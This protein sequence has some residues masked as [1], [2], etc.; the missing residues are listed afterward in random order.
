VTEGYRQVALDCETTGL[1]PRKGS[2]VIEVGCVEVV[3]RRLTGNTW[4]RRV[5]PGVPIDPG[6]THVHGITNA[7]L[8]G[9]PTFA[10]IADE[11]LSWIGKTDI[12]GHNLPF[13]LDH[14][15]NE[16]NKLDTSRWTTRAQFSLEHYC[17]RD[18][19]H[20]SDIDTIVLM[21]RHFPGK[22][23]SLDSLCKLCGVDRS[24]RVVHGALLDA[25]LTAECYLKMT[26]G[27][28]S[29]LPDWKPPVIQRIDRTK[30]GPLV[31]I[32]AT[33][34]EVNEHVSMLEWMALVGDP[35]KVKKSTQSGE[36]N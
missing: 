28:E 9:Q 36:E 11:L 8:V 5:N 19:K 31:V 1:D 25:R 3:N 35:Y 30:V 21:K 4:V 26:A 24:E 2:R 32:D 15:D 29:L 17:R 7:D 22:K 33:D 12:I 13:D 18:G 6:A 10:E 20:R 34:E 23:K 27:Q 16:F 14:L